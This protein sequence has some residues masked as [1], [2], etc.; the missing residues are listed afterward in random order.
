[1]VRS[2]AALVLALTGA[3]LPGM[4]AI[5]HDPGTSDAAFYRAQLDA[6]T[7]S[8][9]GV[10]ASVDPG[11]EW[12]QVTNTGP[13][14]V[15]VQGYSR[16]PY[17]RVAAGSVQENEVSPSAALNRALFTEALPASGDSGGTPMWKQVGTDGVARWHDHRIHWMGAT[18][19]PAVAADPAHPHLV[20][21]WTVQA[22]AD[23]TPVEIRGSLR[24]IGEP[25]I[26]LLG[27][28]PWVVLGVLVVIPICV[29]IWQR[30]RAATSSG[31]PD[32]TS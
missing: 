7:P 29:L 9:T 4:P 5:A 16:E 18:R 11:G 32:S 28:L 3:I 14:V 21:T 22:T 17:L 8:V 10:T 26:R 13:T 27:L 19:P 25:D 24:W 2:V 1:M 23:G 31:H 15:T 30:R 6:V 12:L 20:G